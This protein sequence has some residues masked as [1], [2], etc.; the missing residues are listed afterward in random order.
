MGKPTAAPSNENWERLFWA[1]IKN[2]YGFANKNQWSLGRKAIEAVGA[3]DAQG[4]DLPEEAKA[5]LGQ[6]EI[7]PAIAYTVARLV[8]DIISE[9]VFEAF[10]AMKE[11]ALGLQ[12]YAASGLNDAGAKKQID[13]SLTTLET[14][15]AEIEP[16]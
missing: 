8:L 5:F 3:K 12:K 10:V 14:K 15:V 13:D 9:S 16:T 2:S 4:R 7:G 11:L 1:V 6:I